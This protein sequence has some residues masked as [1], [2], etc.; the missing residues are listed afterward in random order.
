MLHQ[1]QRKSKLQGNK[2][3]W[4]RITGNVIIVKKKENPVKYRNG[5]TVRLFKKYNAYKKF[6][7]K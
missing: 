6:A 3:N 5:E 4:G 2:S 1:I 7:K